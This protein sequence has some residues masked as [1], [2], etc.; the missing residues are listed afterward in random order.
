MGSYESSKTNIDLV[1]D[2]YC[3][4]GC[5]FVT[6]SVSGWLGLGDTKT[7]ES[8]GICF[9]CEHSGNNYFDEKYKTLK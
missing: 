5:P 2:L 4:D 6:G 8:S 7:L 3:L 1:C 9:Y